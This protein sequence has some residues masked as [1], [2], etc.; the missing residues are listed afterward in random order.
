MDY[1]LVLKYKLFLNDR[2]VIITMGWQG[3]RDRIWTYSLSIPKTAL[4]TIIRGVL[5]QNEV[6]GLVNALTE[7]RERYWMTPDMTKTGVAPGH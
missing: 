7:E 4:I 1:I 3:D 2:G 5:I 6:D